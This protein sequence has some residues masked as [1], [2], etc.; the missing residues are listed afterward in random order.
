MD[1]TIA[2]ALLFTDKEVFIVIALILYKSQLTVS[3]ILPNHLFW[4]NS[5]VS[6]PAVI[7][8]SPHQTEIGCSYQ[9]I[10]PV[11]PPQRTL[12]TTD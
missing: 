3:Y 11:S 2:R 5:Y 10:S 7:L 1:V 8:S 6:I 9:F 4:C 12:H